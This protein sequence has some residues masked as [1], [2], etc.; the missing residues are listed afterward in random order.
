[1]ATLLTKQLGWDDYMEVPTLTINCSVPAGNLRTARMTTTVCIQDPNLPLWTGE[2]VVRYIDKYH[3]E[4]I[5]R[6]FRIIPGQPIRGDG[7][8]LHQLGLVPGKHIEAYPV[9]TDYQ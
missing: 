2:D 4:V 9:E 1:M 7:K 8:F 5:E 3:P 6:D